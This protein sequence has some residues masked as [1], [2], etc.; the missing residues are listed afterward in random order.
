M[1]N[2]ATP[3]TFVVSGMWGREH[4]GFHLPET[5]KEESDLVW[6]TYQ[7]NWRQLPVPD[8]QKPLWKNP[9]VIKGS[10]IP[11]YGIVENEKALNEFDVI[12]DPYHLEYIGYSFSENDQWEIDHRDGNHHGRPGVVP[13]TTAPQTPS[14]PLR[15]SD[16]H[17]GNDHELRK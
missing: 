17:T 5:D 2:V 12:R 1:F 10:I 15:E 7:T 3:N 13:T 6:Q 16:L 11:S 9:L 14:K 8:R 4:S